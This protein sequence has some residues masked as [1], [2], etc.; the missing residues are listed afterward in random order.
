M[1]SVTL[2]FT[3]VRSVSVALRC[4]SDWLCLVFLQLL[5]SLVPTGAIFEIS[6]TRPIFIFIYTSL[7]LGLFVYDLVL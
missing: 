4:L 5:V 1:F 3:P 6:N 2:A 7:E